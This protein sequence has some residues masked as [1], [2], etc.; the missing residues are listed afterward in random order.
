M[1]VCSLFPM[2]KGVFVFICV[3][4]QFYLHVLNALYFLKKPVLCLILQA[5]ATLGLKKPERHSLIMKRSTWLNITA[6]L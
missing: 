4:A 1:R 5:S 3:I 2:C 6:T